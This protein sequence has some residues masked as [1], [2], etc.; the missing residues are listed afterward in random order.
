MPLDAV[1]LRILP[2]LHQDS[3]LNNVALANPKAL[4]LGLNMFISISWKE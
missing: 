2:A 4:G 1:D 3:S